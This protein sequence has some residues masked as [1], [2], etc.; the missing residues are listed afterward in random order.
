[1]NAVCRMIGRKRKA[2]ELTDRVEDGAGA[3]ATEGKGGHMADVLTAIRA[4]L[5]RRLE[6]RSRLRLSHAS[7]LSHPIALVAGATRGAV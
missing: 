4:Q 2:D 3:C 5:E 7:D 6:D 1:M